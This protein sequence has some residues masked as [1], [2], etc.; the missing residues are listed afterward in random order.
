MK[1]ILL[2]LFSIATLTTFAQTGKLRIRISEPAGGTT[3]NAG[4]PVDFKIWI[5]NLTTAETFTGGNVV[6]TALGSINGSAFTPLTQPALL[7]GVNIAPGDSQEFTRQYT[8]N[9]NGTINNAPICIAGYYVV[10][11]TA[12]INSVSCSLYNLFNNLTEAEIASSSLK[13]YP[14]PA[15]DVLNIELNYKKGF[16][17]NIFDVTGKLVETINGSEGINQINVAEFKKGFYI[18]DIRTS[19]NEVIKNGKFNVS[20]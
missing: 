5:V 17:I 9:F 1:K 8:I 11:T 14:N 6:A 2:G 3:I 16:V 4:V 13:V 10:G 18:Y 12:T 19:E 7:T 15:K 20:H